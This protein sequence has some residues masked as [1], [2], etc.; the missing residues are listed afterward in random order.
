MTVAIKTLNP[1]CQRV[2]MYMQSI[3][4]EI[5]IYRSLSSDHPNIVKLIAFCREVA[6]S[7]TNSIQPRLTVYMIMEYCQFGNLKNYLIQNK[8]LPT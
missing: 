5:E 7:C 6:S 1:L 2:D 4:Q 8:F 3:Y